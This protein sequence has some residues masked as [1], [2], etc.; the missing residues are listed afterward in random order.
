[1]LSR[2]WIR[3]IASAKSGA[4]ETV[5][6]LRGELDRLRLDRV[7]DDQT[8]NRAAIQALHRSLGEDAVRDHGRYG[9]RSA[10]DELLGHLDQRA[11]ADREV[12]DDDRVAIR[13]VT[14]DLDD[15]RRLVMSFADLVGDG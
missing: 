10:V 15:L 4:T 5:C 3:P 6:H 1:M 13:N 9:S 11:G 14:D 7:G 12:I 2:R 8:L